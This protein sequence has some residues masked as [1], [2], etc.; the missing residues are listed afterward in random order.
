M[1][2]DRWHATSSTKKL[3]YLMMRPF[4]VVR[5]LLYY[6]NPTIK[7]QPDKVIVYDI[8][9]HPL[10]PSPFF[11]LPDLHP[12]CITMHH[13]WYLHSAC[14]RRLLQQQRQK[15]RP[16]AKKRAHISSSSSSSSSPEPSPRV[17]GRPANSLVPTILPQPE[18]TSRGRC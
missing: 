13:L 16:T 5:I 9:L 6:R 1:Q 4:F 14:L 10:S 18:Y 2:N 17:E 8:S 15:N 7:R 11:R 3:P 12:L